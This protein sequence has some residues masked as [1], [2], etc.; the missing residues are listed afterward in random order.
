MKKKV[1]PVLIVLVLI[2][3]IVLGLVIAS[4]IEK[5]TPTTER[6]DLSEYFASESANSVPIVLNNSRSDLSAKLLDDQFY[7]D[8][9]F[10]HDT[11]NSR[12]YWD[13]NEELLFYTTA[14]ELL[15]ITP[16]ESSYLKNDTTEDYGNVI[17]CLDSGTLRINIDFLTEYCD[18]TYA[19]Y[20]DPARLVVHNQWGS[21]DVVSASKDTVIR[22]KGGIKSPIL[23]DLASNV[24]VTVLDEE[25]NWT[26]V[27]TDD[28]IAGYVQNKYLNEKTTDTISHEFEEES[29]SH[30]SK[31]FE[32]CMAWHQVF[33]RDSNSD[34]ASVLSST[35]GVNVISPTWFYLDD[36]DGNLSDIGS[37]DYVNY[38]HEQG[39]EVWALFNNLEDD[40]ADTAYVLTHSSIRHHLVDEIIAKAAQYDLDGINLDFES[41]KQAEV[42][43]AYIQFVREL[44]LKCSANGL[45]LSVDN[46]VPSDYTAFYDRAEQAFFADYVVIMGYDEHYYGSDAGS[47]ASLSWVTEGVTNTLLE[48]PADQVI[49]G[50]PFYTRVWCLTPRSDESDTE[51]LYDVTSEAYGMSAAAKLVTSN[52]AEKQWLEDCGQY[53]VEYEKGGLLYRIWLED[54]A[55]AE[56]RLQLLDEYGLAGASFWK[57][58]LETSDIWDTIETYFQ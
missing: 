39:V 9:S 47:V 10:V 25:E 52:N 40:E 22:Q 41:M 50:M 57:L 17:A 35:K 36:N 7:L 3:F 27:I 38:C 45:V 20:D 14:T 1:V 21:I 24:T 37:L 48:V 32:I 28:G 30:I 51:M 31:D 53:F 13:E 58:G 23:C 34:I 12:F 54:S 5:Y 19:Y 49:L 11:L 18:F 15:T 4:Y 8:F 2:A 29:V 6:A 46:Y 44:A 26:K 56:K 55:S 33:S 42:G 16:G 43:D